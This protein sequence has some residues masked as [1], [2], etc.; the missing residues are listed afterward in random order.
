MITTI[1][2]SKILYL[3][4]DNTTPNNRTYFNPTQ[5]THEFSHFVTRTS[6]SEGS[7]NQTEYW[8]NRIDSFCVTEARKRHRLAIYQLEFFRCHLSNLFLFLGDGRA[9]RII[10]L[11]LKQE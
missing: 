11:S 3:I 5:L 9:I 4:R 2:V 7:F 1:E 8:M 10:A 6:P